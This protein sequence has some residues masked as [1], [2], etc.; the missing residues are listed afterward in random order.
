MESWFHTLKT[1]RVDRATYGTRKDARRQLFADIEA[2][3]NRQR[4]RS[5]LGNLTP[6]T[7]IAPSRITRC[8]FFRRK[9]SLRLS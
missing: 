2:C 6:P 9:I 8:P 1:E 4:L 5:A 3:D 7:G